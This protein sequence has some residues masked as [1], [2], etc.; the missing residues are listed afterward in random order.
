MIKNVIETT[1]LSVCSRIKIGVA[2]GVVDKFLYRIPFIR[3]ILHKKFI[4]KATKKTGEDL[5]EFLAP[6]GVRIESIEMSV[7]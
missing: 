7:N 6:F 3:K 5:Q 4:K 2:F 1:V